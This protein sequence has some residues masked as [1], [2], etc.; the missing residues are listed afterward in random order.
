MKQLKKILSN[1]DEIKLIN[2]IKSMKLHKSEIFYLDDSK[3][4]TIKVSLKVE[5]QFIT[6]E[7]DTESYRPVIDKDLFKTKIKPN[8]TEDIFKKF[9]TVSWATKAGYV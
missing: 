7:V 4:H 3:N 5:D 1:L 9:E 6:A 8:L 2:I